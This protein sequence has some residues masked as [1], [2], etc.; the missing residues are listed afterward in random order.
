VIQ[1]RVPTLSDPRLQR[2]LKDTIRQMANRIIALVT[3]R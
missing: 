3:R 1:I 2:E